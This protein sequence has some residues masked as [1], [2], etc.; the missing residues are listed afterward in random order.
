MSLV[1]CLCIDGGSAQGQVQWLWCVLFVFLC[2]AQC[3]EH[4]DMCREHHSRL[5]RKLKRKRHLSQ[6]VTRRR[7]SAVICITL[8]YAAKAMHGQC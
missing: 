5:S 8:I 7:C 4:A 3:L 6:R 2:I 1:V